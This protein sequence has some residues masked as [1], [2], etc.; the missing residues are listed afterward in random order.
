[1]KSLKDYSEVF[2]LGIGG[3]GMSA[4]ARWFHA[5]GFLVSGYDKVQ[6]PITDSLK[7]LGIEVT[8]I[9]SSGA[10]LE[11]IN[12]E[13]SLVIYT[14]AIPRGSQLRAYFEEN[15]F[16]FVKRAKELGMITSAY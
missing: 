3:I 15:T 1:V 13:T 14:P 7:E 5:E 16:G 2:F 8:D 6:S 9:D 12:R 11:S 4:L 10:L